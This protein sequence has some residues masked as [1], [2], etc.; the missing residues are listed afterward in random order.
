MGR[1]VLKIRARNKN[2]DP[3]PS[4]AQFVVFEFR[5]H[6]CFEPA[7]LSFEVNLGHEF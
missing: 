2:R 1:Q 5:L 6:S 4:R 3:E 7:G